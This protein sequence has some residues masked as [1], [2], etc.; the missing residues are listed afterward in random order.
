MIIETSSGTASNIK[1]RGNFSATSDLKVALDQAKSKNAFEKPTLFVISV[2][3]YRGFAGFRLNQPQYSAHP[4]EKEFLLQ[5]G[6]R[7][8][9]LKV[10][11]VAMESTEPGLEE[12]KGKYITIIHLYYNS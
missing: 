9:V 10:E 8:F 5:D 11:E 12:W 3:N 2:R 6:L 4:H 7:M 1:I